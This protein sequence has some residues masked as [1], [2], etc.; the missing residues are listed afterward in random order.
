MPLQAFK[1]F[2]ELYFVNN[3][4]HYIPLYIPLLLNEKL[5]PLHQARFNNAWCV[6]DLQ[7]V[8]SGFI[9]DL[10]QSIKVLQI[11]SKACR[12]EPI[13]HDVAPSPG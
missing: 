4:R 13:Q 3:I 2:A 11:F 5:K 8:L 1:W 9:W 10:T 12:T 6:H 7:S